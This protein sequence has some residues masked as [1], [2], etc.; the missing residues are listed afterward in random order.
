MTFSTGPASVKH[1]EIIDFVINEI[2][3]ANPSDMIMSTQ[4]SHCEEGLTFVIVQTSFQGRP[5]IL[6]DKT[7]QFMIKRGGK[8]VLMNTKYKSKAKTVGLLNVIYTE[9]Y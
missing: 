3:V 2:D 1:Q 4:V 7:R 5:H 9:T 8:L 6:L